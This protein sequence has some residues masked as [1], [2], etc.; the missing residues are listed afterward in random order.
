MNNQCSILCD[1]LEEQVGKREFNVFP[2]VTH[3][4]LDII[5][6]TAMGK[7]INA[8]EHND[9]DYVRAVYRSSEIV[10]QRQR[11]PWLWYE[12]FFQL[13]PLGAEWRKVVST[14]H[15]FTT[16]VINERKEYHQELEKTESAS[17]DDNDVGIK[18]R[19]AFLDLLIK[20]SKGGAVLSDTDIR[21][22]MVT[23]NI[24]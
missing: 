6:E 8:Q 15:E 24:P 14:M 13:T 2:Y 19:F 4:A 5:C 3:C 7:C 20:E 16:S 12:M 10:F 1:K 23:F 9:T 17:H 11:S 22:D 21:E 18:R